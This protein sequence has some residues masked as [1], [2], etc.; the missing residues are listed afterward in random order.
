MIRL[1]QRR[2]IIPRG[3][4]GSFTIPLVASLSSGDVAVFSII[5]PRTQTLVFQKYGEIVDD[6]LQVKFEHSETVNLPVGKFQWD[7]KVYTEPTLIDNVVVNGTEV[8]SYYAAFELPVCEIRQ[9]ADKLLTSSDSPSDTISAN[10]LNIL[11][12]VLDQIDN[13]DVNGDLKLY[14]NTENE[15]VVGE[16]I[17]QLESSLNNKADKTDTVLDTTLSR[18]RIP[19]TTI[20]EAS[21]A[22][23]SGVIASGSYSH[24]EN[25]G[26]TASGNYSHAEGG[27]TTASGAQA[28]A[29]GGGTTAS[30]TNS[31]AE[32]TST[33]ANKDNAH[34]EGAVTTASGAASHAEGAYTTA[35]GVNSHAEGV[36]TTANGNYSH[37]EGANTTASGT[38]SHAEGDNTIA[39]RNLQHVFGKN[40]VSESTP[41]NS[42]G[43]GLYVEIV[44]NGSGPN[45]LLRSNARTLDWSG[46]EW[47][48][49]NITIAGNSITI[50]STTITESQLQAL[51]A[52]ITT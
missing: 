2:L 39:N 14:A 17:N 4:T 20:G 9:T 31:H 42:D 40:N 6:E 47:L 3:D 38:A 48:A 10:Q 11:Q 8:D 34:A 5:D 13:K 24:A 27:G 15:I 43:T 32:G 22:F 44:G 18:G 7:I 21:F 37:A 30:G 25:G 36:Q 46:N 45:S 26:T 23:G 12:A 1:I 41:A 16:S 51:L 49:G 50:G 33:V 35:S 29:E 28:H 52:L 19:N